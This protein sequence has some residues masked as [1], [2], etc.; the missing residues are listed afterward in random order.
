MCARAK[1]QAVNQAPIHITGC[2]TSMSSWTKHGPKEKQQISKILFQPKHFML[3]EPS[4]AVV[5]ESNG[6][7]RETEVAVFD[8]ESPCV[9]I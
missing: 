8:Q 9:Y 1:S 5:F 3:L 4:A 6:I 7:F 2:L